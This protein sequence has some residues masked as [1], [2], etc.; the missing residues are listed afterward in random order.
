MTPISMLPWHYSWSQFLSAMNQIYS[1]FDQIRRGRQSYLKRT[2][3]PYCLTFP[4][5]L[6]GSKRCLI[7]TKNEK[8]SI[9][10]EI[11]PKP[12]LLPWQ[13]HSGSH[14][15]FYLR[16]IT[17]VKLFAS[18]ICLCTETTSDVSVFSINTC[19][20]LEREKIFQKR[21]RHYSSF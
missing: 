7:K 17:G 16:Y 18:V 15:V 14:F 19:I 4:H 6:I 2:K 11:D 21:K 13:Q 9:G 8:A 3:C 10:H 5:Q 1:I 12:K 20:F